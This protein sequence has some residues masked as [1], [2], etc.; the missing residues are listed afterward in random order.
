MSP[1]TQPATVPTP[2]PAR[3]WR[4]AIFGPKP[5]GFDARPSVYPVTRGGVTRLAVQI[6][7]MVQIPDAPP[8]Q[9]GKPSEKLETVTHYLTW[10]KSRAPVAIGKDTRDGIQP[11][12]LSFDV[13]ANLGRLMLEGSDL[14]AVI[15]APEDM[16]KEARTREEG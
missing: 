12:H 2:A 11:D 8:D 5:E 6:D 14:G 13:K 3:T 7:R 4:E 1:P 10:E 15:L 9:D 16:T